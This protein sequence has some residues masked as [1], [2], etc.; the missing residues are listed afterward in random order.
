[1]TSSAHSVVAV[2]GIAAGEVQQRRLGD[3][4]LAHELVVGLKGALK[5]SMS[6]DHPPQLLRVRITCVIDEEEHVE[7]I[8]V[9]QA[10]QSGGANPG[11][12]AAELMTPAQSPTNLEAN[13]DEGY[14]SVKNGICYLFPWASFC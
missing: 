11:L 1:M 8:E 13:A 2:Y 7:V 9:R 3:G 5:Q 14:E 10:L 4:F 12:W 6:S